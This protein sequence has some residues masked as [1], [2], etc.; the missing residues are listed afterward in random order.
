MLAEDPDHIYTV[1]HYK[2]KTSE[3]KK[4][5]KILYTKR[6][7]PT[8]SIMAESTNL[9]QPIRKLDEEKQNQPSSSI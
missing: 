1:I 8:T 2:L 4:Y 3:V 7:K 6:K 5:D 9:T